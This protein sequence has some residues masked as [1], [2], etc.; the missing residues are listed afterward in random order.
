MF[1]LLAGIV[2]SISELFSKYIDDNFSIPVVSGIGL[3]FINLF[4]GY[5]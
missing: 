1:S 5:L 3:T 4:F 2:G